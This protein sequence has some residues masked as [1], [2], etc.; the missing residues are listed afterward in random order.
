MFGE[1]LLV[2]LGLRRIDSEIDWLKKLREYSEEWYNEL[3]IPVMPILINQN[4][5][6]EKLNIQQYT[7]CAEKLLNQA[8]ISNYGEKIENIFV[9]MGAR[10]IT[11]KS[12]TKL[13]PLINEFIETGMFMKKVAYDF[14]PKK[15]HKE[16][17]KFLEAKNKLVKEVNKQL[18]TIG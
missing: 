5:K 18:K 12:R 15:A 13:T 7:E 4:L 17:K 6:Q 2:K 9:E 14:E 1:N 8:Y 10:G 3:T 11:I 16:W